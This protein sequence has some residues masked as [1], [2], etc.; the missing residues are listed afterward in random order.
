MFRTFS[1]VSAVVLSLLAGQTPT[2]RSSEVPGSKPAS[3]PT[4]P[5]VVHWHELYAPAASE[6]KKAGKLLV[7]FFFD[8]DAPASQTLEE[9]SLDDKETRRF[10]A[11]Y[12]AVRLSAVAGE[13]KKRFA[14]TGVKEA[15][16]VQVFSPTGELLDSRAGAIIPAAKFCERISRSAAYWQAATTR[17]FTPARRWRAVQA[18]LRLAS[19]AK[20]V[21]D[22]DRLLKLPAA[23]RPAGVSEGMLRL[24]RGRAWVR[25]KP[26]QAVKDL[27]AA[28][29]LAPK[30]AAVAGAASLELADL[31]ARADR[32]KQAHALCAAYVKTWPD[33]PMIARACYRKGFLEAMALGQRVEALK[34]LNAFLE[35]RKPN[36]AS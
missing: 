34:T 14:A 7:V 22:I 26:D 30:Q 20:A 15:P 1:A 29:K 23:Q 33:G 5:R 35:K 16:L 10:L 11:D 27:A 31:H 19:R 3:K 28:R 9:L 36:W 17:P 25:V 12:A 2:T 4:P 32:Y 24:A 21:G 18:R 8:P 6:A 13:G